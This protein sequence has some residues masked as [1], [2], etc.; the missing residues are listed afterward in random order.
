MS[1]TDTTPADEFTNPLLGITDALRLSETLR[2]V[3]YRPTR[4]LD[5]IAFWVQQYDA[6]RGGTWA[7][8]ALVG[9]YQ[10]ESDIDIADRLTNPR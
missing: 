3:F 4:N 7:T 6:Q 8:R 9:L 5:M 10:G 2:Q 1:T